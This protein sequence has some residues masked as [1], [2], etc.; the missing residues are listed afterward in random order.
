MVRIA[1]YDSTVQTDGLIQIPFPVGLYGFCKQSLGIFPRIDD[2]LGHRQD[3]ARE[4]NQEKS[5]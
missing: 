1:G 3:H 5:K 2:M 4:E